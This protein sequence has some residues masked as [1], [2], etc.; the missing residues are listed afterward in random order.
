VLFRSQSAVGGSH[1]PLAEPPGIPLT[2]PSHISQSIKPSHLSENDQRQSQYVSLFA[3]LPEGIRN[4][5][6]EVARTSGL[7]ETPSA[8][9]NARQEDHV[10]SEAF[11]LRTFNSIWQYSAIV[12]PADLAREGFFYTGKSE[13]NMTSLK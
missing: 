12:Q 6:T 1:Q 13:S 11:R 7:S 5:I 2:Q 9:A 8:D 4:V 3:S 10:R